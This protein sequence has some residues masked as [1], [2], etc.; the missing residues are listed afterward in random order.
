MFLLNITVSWVLLGSSGL[1]IFLPSWLLFSGEVFVS[2]S[3]T[4]KNKEAC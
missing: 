3:E 1:L 2:D 4:L